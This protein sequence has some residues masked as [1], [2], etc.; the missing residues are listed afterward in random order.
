MAPVKFQA[1]TL[2]TTAEDGA[3]EMDGDCFYGTADAGNRGVIPLIQY[4]RHNADYAL[5][6][7][8]AEQKLFD[9]PTNGTLTLETGV[10]F[11]KAMFRV[12]G[13]SATT[14]N[15]AFDLLGAGSC[16]LADV[17]YHGTGIDNATPTNAGTQ[18]GAFSVAG[19]SVASI[20]T[21]TTATAM[22]VEITGMF[23]VSVAGSIIPSI[24]LVTASA[25]TVSAGAYFMVYKIGATG[26][27]FVGQWT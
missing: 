25:A 14:G 12:T 13:M 3:I 10:Y 22:A 9:N 17:M 4:I 18:T 24:T 26:N 11:F 2:L 27:E 23:D 7:S 20:V 8:A 15:L 21:A 16:T 1:G 6:N 5:A 19:Q